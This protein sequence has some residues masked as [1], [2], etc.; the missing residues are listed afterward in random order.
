MLTAGVVEVLASGK[1]LH[2]LR[3]GT[4]RQFQQSRMQALVQEQVRRQYVIHL[5]INILPP[6]RRCADRQRPRAIRR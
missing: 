4:G 3:P 5:L 1:Y 2:R 6:I